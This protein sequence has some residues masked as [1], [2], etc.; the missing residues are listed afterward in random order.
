MKRKTRKEE[1]FK[2]RRIAESVRVKIQETFSDDVSHQKYI[3][4]YSSSSLNYTK[5]TS[6]IEI[7]LIEI[8][9]APAFFYSNKKKKL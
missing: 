3:Y 6:F 5:I 9:P 8:K 1:Y 4:I 7:A 2:E